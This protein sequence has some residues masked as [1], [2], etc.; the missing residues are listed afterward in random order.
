M[1]LA[2]VRNVVRYMMVGTVYK[3][4]EV[5]NI[6][7]KRERGQ[8][9]SRSM[10]AVNQ[11]HQNEGLHSDRYKSQTQGGGTDVLLAVASHGSIWILPPVIRSRMGQMGL[12]GSI[13]C[14]KPILTPGLVVQHKS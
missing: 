13:L 3:G 2:Q 10:L 4:M 8:H 1:R 6:C 7:E 12:D 14:S 11:R 5:A 9:R